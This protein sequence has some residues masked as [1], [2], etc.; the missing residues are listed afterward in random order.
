MKKHPILFLTFAVLAFYACRS[1]KEEIVTKGEEYFP[2][3]VG[4]RHTYKID[5]V[6]FDLFQKTIDTFSNVVY[7][8]IVEKYVDLNGDT[9]YRIELSTY[10]DVKKKNVVFKSFT[11]NIKNNFAFENMNNSA[12][13]KMIF[14]ISSYKTKG[15]NYTWNANMFNSRDPDIVK[16]TS[17][18]T[19]YNNGSSTFNDCVSVKLN[20]PMRGTINKIKEEV[21]AKN[22]GLVYRFTD[23]TDLLKTPANDTFLSGKR[24]FIKLIN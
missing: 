6:V 14:P 18:F 4:L 9:M 11:R 10:N 23:S 22:I 12:E 19:P 2:L 20:K 21:Y 1:N 17:V 24:I 7:E 8:E 5:T 13:V 15:S 16:Y 3:Q